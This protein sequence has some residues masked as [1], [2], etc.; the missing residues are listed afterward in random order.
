MEYR[1]V[2]HVMRNGQPLKGARVSVS[3]AGALTGVSSAAYTN[4]RGM[5]CCILHSSREATVYVNG[6]DEGKVYCDQDNY[7]HL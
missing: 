4:D 7:I 2:I 1:F 5:A 3:G 6:R